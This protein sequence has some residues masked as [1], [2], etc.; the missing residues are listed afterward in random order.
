MFN[1]QKI[2]TV[3]FHLSV[4]VFFLG[5]PFILSSALGYKFNS[6]TFKFT[7]TGLVSIKTQ[8][9]SAHIYL[10]SKLLKERSPVTISELLPGSY[11][12]RIELEDYYPWSMQVDVQPRKIT[13]VEKVILFPNRTNIKQLNKRSA[14]YFY[15]DQE[16]KSIYYFNLPEHIIYESDLEGERFKELSVLPPWF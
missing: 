6:R 16:K 10:E 5:F 9:Q 14:T 1:E 7:Q 4:A 13:R 8:P 3:L 12:L 2:R 15:V 11:N